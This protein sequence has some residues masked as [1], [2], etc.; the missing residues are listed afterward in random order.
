[1]IYIGIEIGKHNHEATML[2]KAGNQVS[3]SVKFDNSNSG[4]ESSCQ[5]LLT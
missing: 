5:K 4:L 3:E 2:D 1:M